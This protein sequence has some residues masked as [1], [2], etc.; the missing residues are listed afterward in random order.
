MRLVLNG[1]PAQD[2]AFVGA[3]ALRELE[4]FWASRVAAFAP[5]A[6]P[7]DRMWAKLRELAGIT[8]TRCLRG[9]SGVLPVAWWFCPVCGRDVR[10]PG[11]SFGAV[12]SASK[13]V[14]VRGPETLSKPLS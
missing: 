4:N 7:E 11:P 9:C 14:I 6:L 3:P 5:T 1:R 2:V 13:P 10:T 12:A 8:Q